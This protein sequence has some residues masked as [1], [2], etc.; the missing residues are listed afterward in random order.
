VN[1]Y[2]QVSNPKGT[3]YGSRRTAST[4]GNVR[5]VRDNPRVNPR[6]NQVVSPGVRGEAP[7]TSP[8]PST[9]SP[10]A[11]TPRRTQNDPNAVSRLGESP[12]P[13]SVIDGT[14]RGENRRVSPRS[15]Q[16]P[17]RRSVMPSTRGADV[18]SNSTSRNSRRPSVRSSRRSDNTRSFNRRS[19]PSRSSNMSRQSSPSRSS[20]SVSPSRS[21]SPRS[22]SPRSS[23]RSSSPRRGG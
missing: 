11:R 21:S 1:T 22:S 9:V 12:R 16:R 23:S 6:G 14:Q 7:S 13:N 15:T 19:T 20:R 10:A 2:R 4:S 3:Y 8:R 17:S 5:G 18:R